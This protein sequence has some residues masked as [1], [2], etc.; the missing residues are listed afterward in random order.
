[1]NQVLQRKTIVW[2]IVVVVLAIALLLYYQ[3]DRET[4]ADKAT[5]EPLDAYTKTQLQGT[6]L[7]FIAETGRVIVNEN[8][9]RQVVW[10]PPQLP[11]LEESI[12]MAAAA[13]EAGDSEMLPL[14]TDEY[15]QYLR[16]QNGVGEQT[17]ESLTDS[18]T[19]AFPACSAIPAKAVYA[20][21][22]GPAR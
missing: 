6:H 2:A 19:P 21:G 12:S 3:F 4:H 14:C 16:E 8:G 7:G 11:T 15:I 17:S 1:M 18:K 13:K 22:G 5:G 10:D 9:Q 20:P